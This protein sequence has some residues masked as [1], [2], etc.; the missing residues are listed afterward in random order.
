MQ[1]K[2]TNNQPIQT[3][4][5]APKKGR[6]LDM[7]WRA[8]WWPNGN[9]PCN[10]FRWRHFGGLLMIGKKGNQPSESCSCTPLFEAVE[11]TSPTFSSLRPRFGAAKLWGSGPSPWVSF[12]PPW[13]GP[14][15]C[16]GTGSGFYVGSLCLLWDWSALNV[17]SF[18]PPDGWCNLGVF[19]QTA[20]EDLR[21]S[22]FLVTCAFSDDKFGLTVSSVSSMSQFWVKAK[23][24][25]PTNSYNS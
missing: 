23:Q 11:K 18:V 22:L 14:L 12:L 9:I 17:I 7:G 2:S 25:I 21:E 1:Q 24:P 15:W 5:I 8:F 10:Y 3:I 16:A 6:P 19:F 20:V 4:P 13:S